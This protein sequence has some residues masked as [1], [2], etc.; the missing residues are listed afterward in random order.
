[1]NQPWIY[2]CSPSQPPLP[3][4]SP[5]NP[6]G[7]SQ[8]TSPEHLS[9]ASNMGWWSV[10]PLIIYLFQWY[11]LRTSHPCLLPQSPKV[12]SVHLCLFCHL[13]LIS[14]A[15]VR[16]IPFL[17]FIVTIF[18]GNVPLVSL[19]FLKR[20][21]VLLSSLLFSS[22][23][24]QWSPR[25]AFLSFLAILRNSAFR[26]VYLSFLLCLSLLFFSQLFLR[27]PQ[28]TILLFMF[29]FLGDGLDPSLLYNVTSLCSLCSRHSVY[30]V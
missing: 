4:P 11:S 25:K 19:I 14:S 22:I 7:S 12:C 5:S 9:H 1:M 13:F 10:S 6:S 16:P 3:P 20:S 23:S 28:T 18:A 2:M 24:L 30:L 15:S 8:C 21:L 27:P 26:R 29:L 17:S